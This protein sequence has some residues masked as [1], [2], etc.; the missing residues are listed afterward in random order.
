MRSHSERIHGPYRRERVGKVVWR[1]VVVGA[2]RA[3]S[4]HRGRT[5]HTCA[6]EDE[7]I[8]LISTLRTK[9]EGRTVGKAVEEY[10]LYL[11][12]KGNRERSIETTRVR[13]VGM[14]V[15]IWNLALTDVT[16]HR[17]EHVY[18]R[19]A[20]AHSTDTH[21]N[22]LNQV[23]TFR[24]WCQKRGWVKT[25]PWAEVE[26]MGKRSAGKPQLEPDE[27]RQLARV[28]LHRALTDDG[29]LASLLCLYLGLRASEVVGLEKRALNLETGLLSVRVSKTRAGVRRLEIPGV[30]IPGLKARIERPIIFPYR[31]EWVRDSVMRLC[32]LAGVPVVC[33]HGLRGTFASLAMGNGATVRAVADGLG[34]GNDV[35]TTVTNYIAQGMVEQAQ[36]KQAQKVLA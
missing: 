8:A 19:Y 25:N 32:A 16:P 14:L 24:R 10:L 26:P 22:A 7:A 9:V 18:Q 34:H 28:C 12:A 30:L 23:R 15:P 1:V 13:L 29:A 2:E 21:R 4:G 35:H 6:S 11:G 5:T 20:Q 3:D 31:R 36:A 33:A 17:A 27:A